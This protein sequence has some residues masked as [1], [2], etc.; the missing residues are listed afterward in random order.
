MKETEQ[1]SARSK[2]LSPLLDEKS[3]RL[4]YAS[5]AMILGRGGIDKVSK[6]TGVSR[7]T[8]SAG[9]VELKNSERIVLNRTRKKGGGR[10]L[11]IDKNPM[12]ELE[13]A[14]L[15]EPSLR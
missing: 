4:Y 8:I 10:K 15:I 9:L 3:R 1:I 11:S 13:L 6:A 14:K 2:I 5:E 7:T 12:I